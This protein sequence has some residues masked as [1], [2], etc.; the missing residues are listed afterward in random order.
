ED[1]QLEDNVISFAIVEKDLFKMILTP[2]NLSFIHP[3]H[4]I[5]FVP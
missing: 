4:K 2:P 3:S 5:Y 1:A